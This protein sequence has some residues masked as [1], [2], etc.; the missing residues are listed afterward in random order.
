VRAVEVTSERSRT[1]TVT[2]MEVVNLCFADS[3]TTA[4]TKNDGTR[5]SKQGM[6]VPSAI[7]EDQLDV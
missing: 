6:L 3:V 7:P 4:A 5:G 2:R 1:F